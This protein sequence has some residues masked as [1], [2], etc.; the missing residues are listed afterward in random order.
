M[1]QKGLSPIL[2]IILITAALG[3]FVIYQQQSSQPKPNPSPQPTA[4]PSPVSNE[5]ADW[6]TYAGSIYSFEYPSDWTIRENSGDGYYNQVIQITNSAN[7]LGITLSPFQYPYGF[8]GTMDV[9]TNKIKVTVENKDYSA[10]EDVISKRKAYVDLTIQK[11]KEHHI[12]FGTGYPAAS[13]HLKSL[14]D[15]NNQKA[16]MLKIISTL[17]IKD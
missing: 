7:S 16:T 13:D 3:G 10:T 14:E 2:I 12:L 8:G 15:Y 5:T 11:N 4:Q 9:K 17:K 1:N 6:K